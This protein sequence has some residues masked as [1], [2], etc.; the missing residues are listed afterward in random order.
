MAWT[1]VRCWDFREDRGSGYVDHVT[2]L[3]DSTDRQVNGTLIAVAHIDLGNGL[4]GIRGLLAYRPE[5]AEPLMHLAEVLLRGDRATRY[6]GRAE[7]ARTVRARA[8]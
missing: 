4:P 3:A 2:D 1:R 7:P 8:A 5:T 6:L